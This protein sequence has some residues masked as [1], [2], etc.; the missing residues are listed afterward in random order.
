MDLSLTYGEVVALSQRGI[1]W[2][3]LH[4][5]LKAADGNTIADILLIINVLLSLL[6]L[7]LLSVLL[8]HGVLCVTSSLFTMTGLRQRSARRK[9]EDHLDCATIAISGNTK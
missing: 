1:G 8:I 6:L 3:L 5:L 4:Y 2:R 7:S 9:R